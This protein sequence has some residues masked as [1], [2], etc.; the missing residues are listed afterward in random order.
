MLLSLDA[1]WYAQQVLLTFLI[2]MLVSASANDTITDDKSKKSS[3]NPSHGEESEKWRWNYR[4]RS[5]QNGM[6]AGIAIGAIA[7]ILLLGTVVNLYFQSR[8]S[9]CVQ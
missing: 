2:S 7:G 1:N 9:G 4:A 5:N 8:M 3:L 6:M